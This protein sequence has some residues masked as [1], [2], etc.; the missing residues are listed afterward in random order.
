M[1]LTARQFLAELS[2][3]RLALYCL[4]P[5]QL[6][7]LLDDPAVLERTLGFS[8]TREGL[9]PVVHRA[10]R[11]KLEKMAKAVEQDYPWFSYWL[12]QIRATRFGAGLIGFKGIPPH[13]ADVEIGYGIDPACQKHGYMTEAVRGLIGWAFGD[14][15]CTGIY[16]P[17]LI[18]NLASCKVLA[19]AGFAHVSTSEDIV[20]WRLGRQ[21][22]TEK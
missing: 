10:I 1:D 5:A 9:T 6:T 7:G 11:M 4:S 2:T 8:I 18:T 12:I 13:P 21:E 16:A 22:N 3:P 17:V 15:R 14:P 20:F 19:K